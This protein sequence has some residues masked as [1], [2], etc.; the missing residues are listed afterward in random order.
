M[1]VHC[2]YQIG[3]YCATNGIGPKEWKVYLDKHQGRREFQINLAIDT[4]N[5]ALALDWG[6]N[7]DNRPDYVW[8]DAF[9]PCDYETCFF[10]VHGLSARWHQAE[11]SFPLQ[12]WRPIG[13]RG[14]YQKA[15]QFGLEWVSL[16]PNVLPKPR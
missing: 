10:C 4:M 9:T 15:C 13:H 7:S 3:C 2:L 1:V 16:L 12:V 11:G 6:G 5:Y 14:V 8:K